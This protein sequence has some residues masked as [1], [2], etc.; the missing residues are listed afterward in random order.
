MDI[1]GLSVWLRRLELDG[2]RFA[3]PEAGYRGDYIRQIAA[4]LDLSDIPEVG[5]DDLLGGLPE[6]VQF[7]DGQVTGQFGQPR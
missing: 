1:L 3:F 4:N 5:I 7:S 2:A 6:G